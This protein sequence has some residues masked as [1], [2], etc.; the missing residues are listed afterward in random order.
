M[1]KKNKQINLISDERR[2]FDLQ[3]VSRMLKPF[4]KNLLGKYGFTEVDLL[5]NWNEIAGE[6][7]EYTLPKN[8]QYPKGNKINGVLNV[9]VPSGAFALELQHREKFILAKINAFF[10]YEAVGKLK[11]VQNIEMPIQDVGDVGKSQKI[12]VTEEEEN[13]IQSLGEG[14]NNQDL[15]NRLI[16]LGRCIM[17]NNK[18][19]K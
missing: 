1:I 3:S 15:Q 4:A 17:S 9:E 11:I 2:T 19:K 7:A 13:Y 16:S 18:D 10:G 5:A 6:M 14:V 8:L 12:L